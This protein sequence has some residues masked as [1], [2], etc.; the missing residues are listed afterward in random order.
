[1]VEVA[2]GKLI[3]VAKTAVPPHPAA[4]ASSAT[5]NEHVAIRNA[6]NSN[7]KELKWII[8]FSQQLAN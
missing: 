4:S 7:L 1:V 2:A 6:K 3:I 8:T 5:I